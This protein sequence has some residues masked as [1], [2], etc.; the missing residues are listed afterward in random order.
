MIYT[1]VDTV[2]PVL[3]D[4]PYQGCVWCVMCC[5]IPRW[6]VW[7]LSCLERRGLAGQALSLHNLMARL[8]LRF[9]MYPL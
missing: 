9:A 2:E 5:Y 1:Q 8:K 3:S 4:Y 6:I 7:S